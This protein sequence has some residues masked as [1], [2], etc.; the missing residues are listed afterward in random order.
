[1]LFMK[2]I[3]GWFKQVAGAKMEEI[4]I[5]TVSITSSLTMPKGL[6]LP[7]EENP[8][9][10]AAI[11]QGAI[12]A[13][14]NTDSP[15]PRSVPNDFPVFQTQD[16][17]DAFN[18]IAANYKKKIEQEEWK[19]MTTFIFYQNDPSFNQYLPFHLDDEREMEQLFSS[20]NQY[21]KRR[22]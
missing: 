9:F 16:L 6:Y 13:L 7:V 3:A 2:E 14:W 18:T 5:E 15:L 8:N 19:E 11:K 22:G 20:I 21:G 17:F 1:M 10:L 12:A 4:R